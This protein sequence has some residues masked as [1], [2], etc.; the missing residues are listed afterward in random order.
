MSPIFPLHILLKYLQINSHYEQLNKSILYVHE[1]ILE[2]RKMIISTIEIIRLAIP[3]SSGRHE[4]NNIG[5]DVYNA[6]SPA[7][8]RMETLLV[9]ITTDDGIHGWGEGFGHLCNPVT[10]S[11]LQGIVGNFFLGKEI[12]DSPN[13]IQALIME[14]DK[15][16]H[17]FGRSGPIVYALSAIDIALW[18]IVAKRHNM[19]LYRFLGSNRSQIGVY[20]S[21]VSYSEP[22]L[23]VTNA[24][25]ASQAGFK[26]IKLHET[27]YETIAAVRDALP[28]D[29]ELMVDVNC[30]WNVGEAVENAQA[31][32]ELS[33]TWLEEP[34][35][36]PDNITGLAQV[37]AV[38][39]PI[40]AGENANGVQGF[41]QHFIADAIS[42]AQP[43]VAKVGGISA[44]L[45]IIKLA[46]DYKIK[47]VPH[48]FYYGAGLMATAHLVATLPENISLEV[49]YIQWTDNLYPQLAFSPYMQLPDLPGL[50]FEPDSAL[51]NKY[52]I[53]RATLRLSEEVAHVK[54]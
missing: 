40:A 52:C 24:L 6:A 25:R 10:F 12:G 5:N 26:A 1:V 45:Q 44:A 9:R 15:A 41:V 32:R 8:K 3:F 39:V 48:C 47:V 7:L 50:G 18:D 54:A 43:S 21:L 16:L 37:K 49:P 33:L 53:A 4:G 38:G 13:D 36:P 34:V 30:P 51:I 23:A 46:D 42:V 17:A 20:A 19:P 29:I 2:R 27:V 28:Q 22:T 35:Y 14:A 11:A 31:L